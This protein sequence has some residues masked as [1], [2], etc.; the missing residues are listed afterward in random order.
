[1]ILSVFLA[2]TGFLPSGVHAQDQVSSGAEFFSHKIRPIMER[3]C[4]NCHSDQIQSSGLDLSSRDAALTGGSRGPAIVPG[5]ADE[6]R[7]FRQIS[8][9]EGPSMPLGVPLSEDEIEAVRTWINDGAEWDGQAATAIAGESYTAFATD[10]PDSAREYWAFKL[11]IDH[12]LP[13]VANFDHPIDRFLEQRRLDKGVT[14]AP[15]AARLTLLRR[16]YLDLIGLPP[17]I[18]EI[19]AYLTD[20]APGAWERVIDKLLA[21]T[22][23]GER[24]GRHWLDVARYA[25]SDG[26]EQDVDRANA[27]R[28]RDY[29]VDAFNDDKSYA[30][31][32]TEQV[33]GDELDETTHETRIATGFLRAGP[34]VNFREKDNPERRWDYLDDVLATLGRGVLGMTIQCARCHDHKFDPILQKDYYSLTS[35]LFGYVETEYPMLP[36]DQAQEYLVKS[37]EL[38]DQVSAVR[39]QIRELEQP[40]LTELKVERIRR[41]FP[42]DVLDAVLTPEDQRS[43]GQQLLAAQVLTIGVP[44]AQVDAAMSESD[45][46]SREALRG[47]IQAIEASRPEQ[48]AMIEIVTDGDYRYTPDR[49]GDNVLG[50]P[51]CRIQPTDPGSFLHQG[52]GRYEVPP[53]NFLIRGD[54][55]SLGPELEPAYLTVAT[56]GNP[57]TVIPRPNGRTSGRRLALAKWLTSQDNPLT[58]RVWV[59]RVWHHHFGR[60]IVTSLDNFG[61][62]G[63]RPT[64]PEL[65][66]W[67][68]LEFMD[69]G[70]STKQLHRLIMTSEA[71]QMASAFENEANNLA[72]LENHLMWR[73]RPQR[74]EAEAVRDVIMASSSGIDLA[75]GGK[76]I[77]PYIPQDILDTAALFGRWD[78]QADGPDVWRR[79]LYVYRR[80]T[81][82]YP[83]FDTFDLPDQN[84]TAAY[85]N[86]STVAPQALTL[87]NNPFILGQAQLFARKVEEA[88]PYD[89]DRQ[90]AMAYRTALTREPT[91]VEAEIGRQLVEEGSLE[92]LTHV[93]FNLSEF[94]YRR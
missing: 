15:K 33:A 32:I 37:A 44:R 76:P 53:A 78:N 14:A 48:P 94:L 67:L 52:P 91:A 87:L 24:W 89:V 21:S 71:Y 40:Y 92:D 39:E 9:L 18:A 59:N 84:I 43:D 93:I 51:E 83:F 19:E 1:M 38:D 4:W 42:Q 60:G 63:D 8:G 20:T 49:A 58:A 55:F 50:C 45:K 46:T 16:A 31:F 3:T 80:R 36:D 64:H 6:S 25:D 12:P 85:R 82:S 88:V 86:T 34:R 23:Y 79:S 28:Y 65:L 70:W 2:I 27:W 73:Y 57:V 74:L 81:L 90:V 17:T 10:V 62:V 26:Y 13:E 35:A 68:A 47:R 22:Q 41:E 29:V 30:Q 11:P 66:D 61:V 72:D 54:P 7:L 75:V 69:K 56:Y 77:F 5:N